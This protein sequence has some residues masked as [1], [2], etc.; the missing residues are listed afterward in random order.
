MDERI[1][2]YEVTVYKEYEGDEFVYKGVVLAS[3]FAD[4]TSKV[5]KAFEYKG[6]YSSQYDCIICDV[7]IKE[8]LDDAGEPTDIYVFKEGEN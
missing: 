8:Y 1:Y 3:S 2:K 6:E 5:V 4:A 7:T